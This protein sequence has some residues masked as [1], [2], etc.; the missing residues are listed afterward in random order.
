[1]LNWQIYATC[2]YSGFYSSLTDNFSV[3]C[4]HFKFLG[5]DEEEELCFYQILKS[6]YVRDPSIKN[7]RDK[8]FWITFYGK[9][10]KYCTFPNLNIFLKT[11]DV[12]WSFLNHDFKLDMIHTWWILWFVFILWCKIQNNHH[13][14]K[15]CLSES[16]KNLNNS[17]LYRFNYIHL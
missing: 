7:I 9:T 10:K 4:G 3:Y 5:K 17:Q 11:F 12:Y 8:G 16:C 1:M 2:Y 6:W 13:L 15:F 14:L